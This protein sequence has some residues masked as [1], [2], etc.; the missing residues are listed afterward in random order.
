MTVRRVDGRGIPIGPVDDLSE[1]HRRMA[2]LEVQ[3]PANGALADFHHKEV[4]IV[5]PLEAV[6]LDALV[7]VQAE[8][9]AEGVVGLI[10]IVVRRT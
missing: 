8:G 10:A 1:I 9:L 7:D 6:V 4:L 5:V 3:Y 2:D